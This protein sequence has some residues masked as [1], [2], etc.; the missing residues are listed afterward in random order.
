MADWNVMDGEESALPFG[1][2]SD[3]KIFTAL[4]DAAEWITRQEGVEFVI[5]YLDDLLMGWPDSD[6]CEEALSKLLRVFYQLGFPVA[7]SKLEGPTTCMT[8]LGFE[9]DTEAAEV[10]LPESKVMELKE[11]LQQWKGKRSCTPKEL[12]S[13]IGKLGHTAQVVVPGKTFL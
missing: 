9:L 12:E 10:R 11:L 5:H 3:P 2:R 6:E 8:F 1:L 13:L 7:E 4:A